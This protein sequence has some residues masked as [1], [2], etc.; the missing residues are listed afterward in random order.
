[1]QENN[2]Y[3]GDVFHIVAAQRRTTVRQF[4]LADGREITELEE[5][6][7]IEHFSG[8][9][10]DAEPLLTHL[11]SRRVLL[12][13]GDAGARKGTAAAGLAVAL[14]KRGGGGRPPLV[15]DPPDRHTRIQLHDLIRDDAALRDRVVILRRVLSR[16]NPDLA[17]VFART[18]RGRWEVL[19][20]ALRRR[21]AYLVFT[22]TPLEAAAY[23]DVPALQALHRPLPPHPPSVL[24]ERLILHLDTM[25]M[26][27]GA[28]AAILRSLRGAREHLVGRFRYAAH[29]VDFVDFFVGLNQPDAEI[30]EALARF[31][32]A[33][34]RLLH[35]LDDD[36]D[37]WAFGFSLALA[38]CTPHA[39][40]V[41]WVDFDRL[42]R[43][44]HRWL[45][46]DLRLPDTARP[47]EHEPESSEVRLAL[48]DDSLLGRAQ[49]VVEKDRVT[50]ADVV[51]FRDG[52][53]PEVLWRTL[54]RCH[55]RVLSALVPRLRELAERRMT[56][57]DGTHV[58]AAQILGRIGEMDPKR[59]VAPLA[60]R[61]A[62]LHG[63]R[64]QMLVGAL[65]EGAMAGDE[66]YRSHCLGLLAELQAPLD[67]RGNAQRVV[68][69]AVAYSWVGF[70]DLALAMPPLHDLLRTHL[71]PLVEEA[72]SASR[73]AARARVSVN[74]RTRV[75]RAEA[76]EMNRRLRETLDRI[77]AGR[78]DI[79]IAVQHTLLSLC[80][81]HGVAE[82]VRQ[83]RDWIARGGEVTG[84]V[85][86]MMFYRDGGLAAQL[87]EFLGPVPGGS[88]GATPG[89]V[90]QALI[91]GEAAVHHL[92]R[93]L[94][95]LHECVQMPWNAGADIRRQADD[96]LADRLEGWLLEAAS[97]PDPSA[98]G[99]AWALLRQLA[100]THGG[101]LR[102]VVQEV[103]DAD[104]VRTHPRL[105]LLIRTLEG[106]APGGHVNG[107]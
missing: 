25:G 64:Q 96:Q 81:T 3:N 101:Q 11:E 59:I 104:A 106:S 19:G 5:Q 54:L 102:E 98:A 30:D 71:V 62:T 20:E 90:V 86:A 23:A 57:G 42:R 55:R 10:D 61:W 52:T 32:D 37:G 77:F 13:S 31:H 45:R 21:G 16:G 26:Q 80:L 66:R 34:R 95:D 1:M 27:G 48:S 97:L 8:M 36:F 79:F 15:V 50:L 63:G 60:E 51:R 12:L 99:Y 73:L 68:A 65:F 46:Q 53:S 88:R 58:L 87:D 84:V 91:T 43:N 67:T 78:G 24:T 92:A 83:L 6:R 41:A 18:D 76:Q 103:V 22:A 33:G 105:A 29:L 72:A 89:P 44:L 56:E 100:R 107:A 9:E 75:G 28:A 4:S 40:G 38:Q 47:D 17:E 49:A 82:V 2:V 39:D 7:A 14:R 74:T 85:L 35:D 70:H 93:F 69:A 94:A